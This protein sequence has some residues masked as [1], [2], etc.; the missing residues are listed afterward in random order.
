[1]L[2]PPRS[3]V[4][5]VWRTLAATPF[6]KRLGAGSGVNRQDL[7]AWSSPW[8]AVA[9]READYKLASWRLLVLA[10]SGGGGGG[11]I[12][13]MLS[14]L[15]ALRCRCCPGRCWPLPHPPA[16]MV[17]AGSSAFGC[18]RRLL[19]ELFSGGMGRLAP[20]PPAG[21]DGCRAPAPLLLCSSAP[22][23]GVSPSGCSPVVAWRPWRAVS[24]SAAR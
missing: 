14:S 15:L 3:E 11:G 5:L 19:Q 7:Q 21:L 8:P 17:A 12:E 1:V 20:F 6:D 13:A 9:A 24:P 2:S 4:D 10:G 23:R 16:S 22:T 18:K